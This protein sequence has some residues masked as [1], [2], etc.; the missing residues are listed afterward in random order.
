MFFFETSAMKIKS[1]LNK[2]NQISQLQLLSAIGMLS[3]FLLDFL[4]PLG[5]SV[6][7]LYLVCFFLII[8]ETPKTIIFFLVFAILFIILDLAIVYQVDTG[9]ME[10][11]DVAISV[12]AVIIGALM[13]IKYR[14]LLEKTNRERLHYIKSLEEMLFMTSHKVRKPV[15]SCLGLMNI[16]DFANPSGEKML[17]V[18]EHM[19]ASAYELDTFT[20]ELTAFIQQIELKHRQENHEAFL[21]K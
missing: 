6:S 20:R 9:W 13:S 14:H 1:S 19:K 5:L 11:A 8:R 18:V 3:V 7:L 16:M 2:K 10:I 12:F 15:A 21:K 4:F 17:V